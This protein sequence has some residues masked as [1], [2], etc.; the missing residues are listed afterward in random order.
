[1][2]IRSSRGEM[3]AVGE[4]QAV[5]GSRRQ[6]S[7]ALIFLLSQRLFLR[8]NVLALLSHSR[9]IFRFNITRPK[10]PPQWS[11]SSSTT[12]RSTSAPRI[13]PAEIST[14]SHPIY[15]KLDD[16]TKDQLLTIKPLQASPEGRLPQLQVGRQPPRT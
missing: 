2:L 14:R 5:C 10:Q 8:N 12:R 15:S 11:V 7:T 3:L 4:R 6:K 9:Y 13:P 1:M 16:T